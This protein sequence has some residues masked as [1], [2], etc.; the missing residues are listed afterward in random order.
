M[1]GDLGVD[2][3]PARLDFHHAV[4][5]ERESLL[6]KCH[7]E[8]RERSLRKLSEPNTKLALHN[9]LEGGPTSRP[10]TLSPCCGFSSL[11]GV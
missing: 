3:T 11:F 8:L 7:Y 9:S 5:F 10:R 6:D 2:D 4:Q 1:L